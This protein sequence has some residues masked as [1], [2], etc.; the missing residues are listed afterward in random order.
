MTTF[1]DNIEI[2]G[3]APD[4]KFSLI[5]RES[6]WWDLEVIGVKDIETGEEEK[7]TWRISSTV[8]AFALALFIDF[9]DSNNILKPQM[10]AIV[11]C[12]LK[13]IPDW[14]SMIPPNL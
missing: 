9:P 14:L 5:R 7:K 1:N 12:E 6:G 10:A 2:S 8:A 11:K 3:E 13:D 4:L